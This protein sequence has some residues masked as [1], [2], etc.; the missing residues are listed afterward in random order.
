MPS[1]PEDIA[2]RFLS[3]RQLEDL[4]KQSEQSQRQT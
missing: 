3:W 2:M 1:Y 4:L